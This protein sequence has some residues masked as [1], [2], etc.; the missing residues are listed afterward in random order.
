M[1][2]NYSESIV[3]EFG[4]DLKSQIEQIFLTRLEDA[5][6]AEK[7]IVES[8]MVRFVISERAKKFECEFSEKSNYFLPGELLFNER[9][10][11]RDGILKGEYPDFFDGYD[12]P[13]PQFW[14]DYKVYDFAPHRP[15]PER[16]EK[17]LISWIPQKFFG[18]LEAAPKLS[19][20]GNVYAERDLKQYEEY[21]YSPFAADIAQ[22]FRARLQRL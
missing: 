14:M 19:M 22:E 7:H 21:R 4:S 17:I 12:N 18:I 3:L 6:Y 10:A 9:G 20:C 11:V 8:E 15:E 5:K 13:P 1:I 16:G 2:S